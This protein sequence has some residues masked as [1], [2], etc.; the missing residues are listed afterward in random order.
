[1][2]WISSPSISV[3]KFG[4][5]LIHGDFYPRFCNSDQQPG[6]VVELAGLPLAVTLPQMHQGRL[7][8]GDFDEIS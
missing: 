5:A 4:T 1:M 2:K 8:G 3:M 6:E 7:R